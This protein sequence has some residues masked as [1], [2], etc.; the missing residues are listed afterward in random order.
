VASVRYTKGMLISK[1][2]LQYHLAV[3]QNVKIWQ[4]VLLFVVATVWSGLMLRQNS[5]HMIT[6]RNAVEKADEQNNDID[7]TLN[8]LRHYVASHMNT[9]MGDRGIYLEHS[10]QRAYD[11]AVQDAQQGDGAAV[12]QKADK[13]CQSLFSRTASFPAYIQCVTDK[14]AAS[15]SSQDPVAAIKAPSA[16]L[17]RY[18]FTPPG[19]SPDI[20]GWSVLVA[21]LLGILILLRVIFVG[22]IHILLR[23]SSSV[24]QR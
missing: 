3:I 1:R 14:V 13:E 16:D 20:A 21:I 12:Y 2:K 24:K 11:Q 19:W 18:N 10:Y 15:G 9:S 4:L 22:L 8:D 5:L 6:L 17:F 7:N 23:R